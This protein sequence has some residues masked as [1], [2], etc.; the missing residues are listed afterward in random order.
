MHEHVRWPWRN[1]GHTHL[2]RAFRRTRNMIVCVNEP[3]PVPTG[4][5]GGP[6]R[7]D[8]NSAVRVTRRLQGPNHKPSRTESG[9]TGTSNPESIRMPC[10]RESTTSARA[11]GL[12]RASP[13]GSCVH[14]PRLLVAE[15]VLR[16]NQ[17]VQSHTEARA[18]KPYAQQ[19]LVGR[20]HT[21][22]RAHGC[23]GGAR[24]RRP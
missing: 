14:T 20:N 6:G 8:G 11:C 10:S 22:Q 7:C 15:A 12:A 16:T 2:S 4:W 18:T 5:P 1:G 9:D 3:P 13:R 24:L 19:N 21:C 23:K 17:L